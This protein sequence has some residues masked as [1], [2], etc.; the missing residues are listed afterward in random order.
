MGR[1]RQTLP[2]DAH[3]PVTVRECAICGLEMITSARD[4]WEYGEVDPPC[5]SGGPAVKTDESLNFTATKD[6]RAKPI[7]VC[8]Y[9]YDS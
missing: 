4:L 1:A 2:S 3:W 7:C 9:S 6:T 8:G 5:Q